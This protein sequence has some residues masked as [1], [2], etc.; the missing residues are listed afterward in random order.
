MAA[1][2]KQIQTQLRQRMHD[3]LA[4]TAKWLQSVVRGLRQWLQNSLRNSA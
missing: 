3:S 1:E 4:E 2:L